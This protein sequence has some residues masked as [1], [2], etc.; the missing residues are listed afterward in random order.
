MLR[1]EVKLVCIQLKKTNDVLFLAR[2]ADF[3]ASFKFSLNQNGCK[4]LSKIKT[5]DLVRQ[6]LVLLSSGSSDESNQ[7]S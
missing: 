1:F 3:L 5:S 4:N 7:N 6:M 2:I